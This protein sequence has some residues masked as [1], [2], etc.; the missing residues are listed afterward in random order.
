VPGT[1]RGRFW[2]GAIG[3][4]VVLSGRIPTRIELAGDGRIRFRGL[5]RRIEVQATE[6]ESIKPRAQLGLL[7]LK[8]SG[9]RILLINQFDGFHE[10]LV[11]L[12][13]LN[14]SVEL[15]GC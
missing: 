13:G 11:A 5:L 3:F 10:F 6:I 7:S 15:R 1:C 9:G 12:K 4:G 14:P 2:L 8:H